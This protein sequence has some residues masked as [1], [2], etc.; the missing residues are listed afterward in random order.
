MTT[1]ATV[2]VGTHHFFFWKVPKFWELKT[3][4]KGKKLI[5]ENQQFCWPND[6][7]NISHDLRCQN[8]NHMQKKIIVFF[9]RFWVKEPRYSEKKTVQK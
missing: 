8:Q 1:S 2:E 5:W 9:R 3:S 6:K 7:K 4:L